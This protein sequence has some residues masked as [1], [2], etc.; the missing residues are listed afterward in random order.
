L[1]HSGFAFKKA[2]RWWTDRTEIPLPDNIEEAVEIQRGQGL[3]DTMEITT[4]KDGKYRRIV[5]YVLGEKPDCW[6]SESDEFE[7]LPF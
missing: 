1:E 6:E 5:S 2:Q 3:A 4:Q 7:E